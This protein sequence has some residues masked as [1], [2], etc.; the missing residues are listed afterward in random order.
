M[1][2]QVFSSEKEGE[3]VISEAESEIPSNTGEELATSEAGIAVSSSKTE[4]MAEAGS[5]VSSNEE[6]E[7]AMSV[8]GSVFLSNKGSNKGGKKVV[9]HEGHKY[10][11]EKLYGGVEY[12]V[13]D[14]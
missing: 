10:C 7:M 1:S 6:E 13:C 12:Y 3:R 11:F 14:S 5:V 8:E 9:F 4:G 2:T